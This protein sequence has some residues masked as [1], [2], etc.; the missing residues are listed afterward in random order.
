MP[1]GKPLGK[2]DFVALFQPCYSRLWAL[3]AAILG[4]RHQAEDVVQESGNEPRPPLEV[5]AA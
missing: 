4:D 5:S 1:R 3:A 2:E